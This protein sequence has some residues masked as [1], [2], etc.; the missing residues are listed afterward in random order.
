VEYKVCEWVG[1]CC[2]RVVSSSSSFSLACFVA[3]V[4][5]VLFFFWFSLPGFF[6]LLLLLP[7]LN[8]PETNDLGRCRDLAIATEREQRATLVLT[9]MHDDALWFHDGH[10]EK[11]EASANTTS[12]A[13][14]MCTTRH[15]GGSVRVRSAVGLG[16][17]SRAST[18]SSRACKQRT[19]LERITH[20]YIRLA[21]ALPVV[22]LFGVRVLLQVGE[23]AGGKR[24]ELG[25]ESTARFNLG[26]LIVW[27][28]RRAHL[29]LR[30]PRDVLRVKLLELYSSHDERECRV[31]RWWRSDVT[32]N[33]NDGR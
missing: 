16:L 1:R 11:R 28:I 27:I 5:F 33:V 4:W 3:A 7:Y 17:L 23:H 30:P 13:K 32:T 2:G 26:D 14:T 21:H 9:A 12:S 18:N 29:A 31:G 20:T 8:K 6:L 19:R 25:V 22:P 24:G 10:T 15:R